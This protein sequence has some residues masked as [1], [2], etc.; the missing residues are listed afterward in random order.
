M[1]VLNIQLNDIPVD[2]STTNSNYFTRQ[3]C[4][5]FNL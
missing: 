5:S 1:N 2:F 4:N 3:I